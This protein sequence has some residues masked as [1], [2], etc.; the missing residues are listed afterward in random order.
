MGYKYYQKSTAI[1]R[2]R[3]GVFEFILAKSREKH[4]NSKNSS[5][6]KGV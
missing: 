1:L 4:Q 3:E 2:E 5:K 6:I